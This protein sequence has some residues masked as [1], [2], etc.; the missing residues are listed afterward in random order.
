M[1]AARPIG[2]TSHDLEHVLE[3]ALRLRRKDAREPPERVGPKAERLREL[4]LGHAERL[5]NIVDGHETFLVEEPGNQH[6]TRVRLRP[7][8]ETRH[9]LAPVRFLLGAPLAWFTRAGL[10]HLG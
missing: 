5:R 8:P 7:V 6:S 10:L 2:D 9:A 3:P 1:P 4:S